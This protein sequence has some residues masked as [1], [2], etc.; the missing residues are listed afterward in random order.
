MREHFLEKG[1]PSLLLEG[2]FQVGPPTG[3]VL[4]R[5]KAFMEMLL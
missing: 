1:I 2:N 3:Q 4:T 5:L